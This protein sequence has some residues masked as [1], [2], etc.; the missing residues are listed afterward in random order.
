MLLEYALLGRPQEPDPPRLRRPKYPR[1][2]SRG[3][4]VNEQRERAYFEALRAVEAADRAAFGAVDARAPP[5]LAAVD[6]ACLPA[7]GVLLRALRSEYFAPSGLTLGL[8]PA[9]DYPFTTAEYAKA[10]QIAPVGADAALLE[11]ARGLGLRARVGV[12][13][14]ARALLDDGRHLMNPVE[15]VLAAL[16]GYRG[17]SVSTHESSR[18]SVCYRDDTETYLLGTPRPQGRRRSWG[19]GARPLAVRSDACTAFQSASAFKPRSETAAL[20]TCDE[21]QDDD[22]I[23]HIPGAPA[24]LIEMPPSGAAR[25][26]LLAAAG[27]APRLMRTPRAVNRAFRCL[28]DVCGREDWKDPE[29]AVS[30]EEDELDE[31]VSGSEGPAGGGRDGGGAETEEAELLTETEAPDGDGGASAEEGARRLGA[32]A[33]RRMWQQRRV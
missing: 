11:A 32:A 23:A 8:A 19:K 17:V 27:G 24:L 10:L 5:L 9:H 22:A 13:Y 31:L 20:T 28:A 16:P 21:Q 30:G 14:V 15:V 2:S 4:D 6:P 7:H 12:V 18:S 29:D 3:A 25:R 1:W 33:S 26:A